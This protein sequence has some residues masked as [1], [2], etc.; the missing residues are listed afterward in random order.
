MVG[1]LILIDLLFVIS[2]IVA[3]VALSGETALRLL[4]GPFGWAISKIWPAKEPPT[5]TKPKVMKVYEHVIDTIAF[6]FLNL[7]AADLKGYR[8]LRTLTGLTFESAPQIF[9]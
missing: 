6:K 8:R 4:A 1:Y 5:R 2:T 3:A 7:N 9:L